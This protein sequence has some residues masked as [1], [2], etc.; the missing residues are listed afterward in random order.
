MRRAILTAFLAILVL[1]AGGV[2]TPQ[3]EE[4]I[5]VITTTDHQGTYAIA[6]IIIDPSTLTNIMLA[7]T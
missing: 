6:V 3:A 4:T 2:Q 7:C 5:P 1:T